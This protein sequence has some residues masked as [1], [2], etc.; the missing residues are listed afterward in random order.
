[1]LDLLVKKKRIINADESWINC[2]DF[3]HHKWSS[4]HD[5]GSAPQKEIDPR[6]SLILA[7][8]NWG[9]VYVTLT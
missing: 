7:I 2:Q 3:R 8:D 4:R 9:E 5:N 6:I 1:M